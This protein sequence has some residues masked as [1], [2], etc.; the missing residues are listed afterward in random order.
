MLNDLTYSVNTEDTHFIFICSQLGL[1][2]SGQL[3]HQGSCLR[4]V[5]RIGMSR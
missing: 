3:R 2:P 4:S 1:S 5:L